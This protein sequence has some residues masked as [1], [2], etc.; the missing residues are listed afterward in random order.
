MTD[1]V[2]FLKCSDNVPI[3][4]YW[5]AKSRNVNGIFSIRTTKN[6][7]KR[8]TPLTY[9]ISWYL[10]AV[11]RGC[12]HVYA[13]MCGRLDQLGKQALYDLVNVNMSHMPCMG[14]WS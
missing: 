5:A 13:C 12:V 7:I 3:V 11:A 10:V 1:E 14:P 8:M 9:S 6:N 2:Q 4:V